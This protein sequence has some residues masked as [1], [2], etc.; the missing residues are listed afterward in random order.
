M[1]TAVRGATPAEEG[2]GV[3]AAVA[4]VAEDGYQNALYKQDICHI[5]L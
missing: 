2:Q 4:L 1:D 5:L 3:L